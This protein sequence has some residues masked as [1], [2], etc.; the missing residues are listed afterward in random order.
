MKAE[1]T[2]ISCEPYPCRRSLGLRTGAPV[3]SICTRVWC[4][5]SSSTALHSV[6]ENPRGPTLCRKMGILQ[7]LAKWDLQITLYMRSLIGRKFQRECT[8][9]EPKLQLGFHFFLFSLGFQW[10]E[11]KMPECKSFNVLAHSSSLLGNFSV[12]TIRLASKLWSKAPCVYVSVSHWIS[13]TRG[14]KTR[15][16]KGEQ[17]ILHSAQRPTLCLQLPR[18]RREEEGGGVSVRGIPFDMWCVCSGLHWSL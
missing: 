5:E 10:P 15:P 14:R 12:L 3:K 2:R 1:N 9:N 7:G 17:R 16:Q 13:L 8:I 11:L 18:L 6:N 4:T